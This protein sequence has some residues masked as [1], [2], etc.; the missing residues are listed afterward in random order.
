MYERNEYKMKKKFIIR[1]II[2]SLLFGLIVFGAELFS[3][4]EWNP[5]GI[6]WVMYGACSFG[7]LFYFLFGLIIKEYERKDGTDKIKLTEINI[8]LRCL[9]IGL[10][11]G[12]LLSLIFGKIGFLIVGVVLGLI[13][14]IIVKKIK[15]KQ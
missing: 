11:A 15:D 5:R 8:F 13:V 10:M 12:S 9:A 2:G 1:L 4:G 14:G 6:L 7:I 3:N